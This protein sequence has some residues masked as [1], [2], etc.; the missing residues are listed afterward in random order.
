MLSK[1]NINSLL[2]PFVWNITILIISMNKA[3]VI[4]K[5]FIYNYIDNDYHF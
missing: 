2:I 3:I 1:G 5:N 4:L